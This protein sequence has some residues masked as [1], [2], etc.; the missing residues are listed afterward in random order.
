MLLK[1]IL[2]LFFGAMEPTEPDDDT[3]SR[4]VRLLFGA[5]M[6]KPFANFPVEYPVSFSLLGGVVGSLHEHLLRVSQIL[7]FLK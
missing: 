4:E 3:I 5:A 2:E 7:E 6:N 1:S